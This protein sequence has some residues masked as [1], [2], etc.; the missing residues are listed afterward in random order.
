[1]KKSPVLSEGQL[2]EVSEAMGLVSRAGRHLDRTLGA[3]QHCRVTVD[4]QSFANVQYYLDK[5]HEQLAAVP[6]ARINAMAENRA[7]R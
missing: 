5:L 7:G 2:A 6:L 3:L 4:A 1:M